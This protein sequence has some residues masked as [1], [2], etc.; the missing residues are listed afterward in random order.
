M[1]RG[2]EERQLAAERHPLVTMVAGGA[3]NLTA[4]SYRRAYFLARIGGNRSTVHRP[5][6]HGPEPFEQVDC[7]VRLARAVA[8]SSTATTSAFVSF[9]AGL[10][11]SLCMAG[12]LTLGRTFFQ[13]RALGVMCRSEYCSTQPSI[14]DRA[15]RSRARRLFSEAS[16]APLRGFRR[17]AAIPRWLPCHPARSL[18]WPSDSRTSSPGRCSARTFAGCG[19]RAGTATTGSAP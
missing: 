17:R 6:V 1:F 16:A 13:V 8:A 10:S 15:R 19:R 12:C 14:A 5:V 4:G 2:E 9:S 11:C 18:P 3:S 7:A